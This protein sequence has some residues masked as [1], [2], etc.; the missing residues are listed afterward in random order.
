[1]AGVLCTCRPL[2]L[3]VVMLLLPGAVLPQCSAMFC[4][5]Q[6]YWRLFFFAEPDVCVCFSLLS[7]HG[8]ISV[9][10]REYFVRG[11]RYRLLFLH[12][13]FRFP[14]QF[15]FSFSVGYF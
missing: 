9:C 7:L 3:M 15:C 1:M 5:A 8:V 2:V 14:F 6:S 11:A 12:L 4:V 10:L 13:V